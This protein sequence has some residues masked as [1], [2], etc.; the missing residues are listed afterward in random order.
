MVSSSSHSLMFIASVFIV[1]ITAMD[2]KTRKAINAHMCTLITFSHQH[3]L[4]VK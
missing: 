1:Y 4:Y 3:K 2:G